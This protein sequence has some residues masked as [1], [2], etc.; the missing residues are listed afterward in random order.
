MLP[1]MWWSCLWSS[2]RFEQR[3]CRRSKFCVE[4]PTIIWE[5]QKMIFIKVRSSGKWKWGALDPSRGGPHKTSFFSSSL[6]P[7]LSLQLGFRGGERERE[8][9]QKLVK[10]LCYT[11]WP[12]S[13][14]MVLQQ[15]AMVEIKPTSFFRLLQIWPNLNSGCHCARS[16]HRS[17][18]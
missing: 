15:L 17:L 8:R 14:V 5:K 4:I 10:R 11:V 18:C 6:L 13:A 1:N 7:F 12:K 16:K 9:A 2:I 3:K